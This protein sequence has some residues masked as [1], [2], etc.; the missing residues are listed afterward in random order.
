MHGRDAHGSAERLTNDG[1][2]NLFLFELRVVQNQWSLQE[3][4]DQASSF[5]AHLLYL[6]P[7]LEALECSIKI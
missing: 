2:G 6:H 7:L 1:I 4:G 3:E 5:E